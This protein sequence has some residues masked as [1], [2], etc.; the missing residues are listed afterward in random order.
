MEYRNLGR[1]GM[2]VSPLCLGAMMF[3]AQTDEATSARIIDRAREQ[4]VNFID[5]ADAYNAGALRGGRRPR[6]R[7]EPRLVGGRD[8]ARQPDRPR[9][10]RPRP[11]A[12]AHVPRGRGEPAAARRRIRSTS[13]TCTRKT[14]RRRWRRLVHAM[15]DLVRTGRIRYFGVSNHRA[16]RVAEICRLCDD[17]R[18]STG[19]SSAS[20][21]TTR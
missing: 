14:M 2:K 7:P 15:A 17:R 6:D 19:R 5:T 1:S 16:W 8:Q 9:A 4:G 13:S 18:A 10:E 12:A 3:G 21:S 11:L 20:R